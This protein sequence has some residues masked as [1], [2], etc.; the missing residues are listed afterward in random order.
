MADD[1]GELIPKIPDPD[2]PPHWL[3]TLKLVARDKHYDWLVGMA[4][5]WK[6]K[7]KPYPGPLIEHVLIHTH[8]KLFPSADEVIEEIELM[9]EEW[10]QEAAEKS[11]LHWKLEQERAGREG[12]LATEADYQE[13]RE[14][15]KCLARPKVIEPRAAKVP[16]KVFERE[17]MTEAQ[18]RDRKEMLRQ[19][20]ATIE[21]MRN[22]TT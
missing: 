7:L 2:E 19:Q 11:W 18:F 20:A 5:F 12:L 3:D 6:E 15:M 22:R 9:R 17:P 16:A 21:A 1:K 10:R 13:L 14:A 8:W 4:N